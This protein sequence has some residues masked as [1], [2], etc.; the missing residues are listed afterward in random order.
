[1]SRSYLAIAAATSALAG[2]IPT[3][4]A[5]PSREPTTPTR[6]SVAWPTENAR[7]DEAPARALLI[8]LG[9]FRPLEPVAGLTAGGRAPS[10]QDSWIDAIPTPGAAPACLLALS[11]LLPAK[12]SRRLVRC[13]CCGRWYA[14]D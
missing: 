7:P 2:L 12:P 14:A 8:M 6:T 13:S 1:M 9:E 11:A 3:L 4:P 10:D 5:Q